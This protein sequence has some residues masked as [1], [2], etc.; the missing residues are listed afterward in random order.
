MGSLGVLNSALS[1]PGLMPPCMTVTRQMASLFQDLERQGIEVA[2]LGP[3]YPTRD[4]DYL[5][6]VTETT[7]YLLAEKDPTLTAETIL[8]YSGSDGLYRSREA[9]AK[10]YGNDIGVKLRPEDLVP[11]IGTTGAMDTALRVLGQS[12][13]DGKPV[14]V[15]CPRPTYTGWVVRAQQEKNVALMSVN[16]D[17][18]GLDPNHFQ[19]QIDKA[20][21]LGFHPTAIYTIP[22]GD[23]PTGITYTTQ[24]R[25]EIVDVLQRNA[26]LAFEDSA[27][28]YMT[29]SKP[30]DR[31]PTLMSL[32]PAHVIQMFSFSKLG[33][34]GLRAAYMVSQAEFTNKDGKTGTFRDQFVAQVANNLLFASAFSLFSLEAAIKQAGGE[35]FWG[36][37][38]PTLNVYKENRDAL[39][40]VLQERLGKYPDYFEWNTP[41]SGFFVTLTLKKP[42]V[43]VNNALNLEAINKNR[44]TF[45]PMEGF[46]AD[47]AKAENPYIGQNEI[48]LAYSFT[49]GR[50]EKRVEE[51]RIAGDRL[52]DFLLEKYG[53][54]K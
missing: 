49:K 12:R 50:G 13:N 36:Y 24:R 2:F 51:V 7:N 33:A 44:V 1:M 19:Y 54:K 30:E 47:D 25:H 38:E 34:P 11:A 37:A 8:G 32:D 9:F 26:V 45:I 46:Y 6:L 53:L 22:T 40:E 14:A 43:V 52:S 41:E 17:K 4:R 21:M 48:R 20:K 18:D 10:I 23:N 29:F 15:F 27:Y 39:L 5:S 28:H 31:P 42:G 35:T 16:M 3:G